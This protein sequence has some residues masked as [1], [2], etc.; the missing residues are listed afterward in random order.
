MKKCGI[1]LLVI[2][3]RCLTNERSCDNRPTGLRSTH[4]IHAH[5]QTQAHRNT[6]KH[7]QV[8]RRKV[9]KTLQ[10]TH[11]HTLGGWENYSQ[12]RWW[13]INTTVC[14]ILVTSAFA[15]ISSAFI[16]MCMCF[17]WYILLHIIIWPFRT[18]GIVSAEDATHRT[19]HTW[20]RAAKAR[21]DDISADVTTMGS[22]A[23]AH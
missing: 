17:L 5:T 19:L 3:K 15:F 22:I 6:T 8:D 18:E 13:A 23:N 10:W 16:V 20:N 7:R 9:W 1:F 12:L 11:T 4:Q 14:R 21:V 2:Y